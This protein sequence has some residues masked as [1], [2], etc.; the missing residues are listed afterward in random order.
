MI[1][2]S[3]SKL[4]LLLFFFFS[5]VTYVFLLFTY[6]FDFWPG[7][8][9]QLV[10]CC[11]NSQVKKGRKLEWCEFKFG[12]RSYALHITCVL[13]FLAMQMPRPRKSWFIP[14]NTCIQ[15]QEYAT[16]LLYSDWLYFL[17]HG[18]KDGFQRSLPMVEL[19]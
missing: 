16:A 6:W 17:W 18:I 5:M 3:E 12:T 14:R 10:T 9:I 2:K 19:Y 11:H 13:L 7:L 4:L 8:N 15:Q 1:A